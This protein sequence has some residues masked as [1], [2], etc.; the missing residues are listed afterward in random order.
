[1]TKHD[2]RTTAERITVSLEAEP[3]A[4]VRDAVDVDAQNVSSWMAAAARRQLAARGLREV[5]APW[6]AEHGPFDDAELAEARARVG[7]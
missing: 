7:A 1:M 3:A 4:A 2:F 6:E 5:V